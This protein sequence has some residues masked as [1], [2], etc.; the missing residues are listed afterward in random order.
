MRQ[1]I[2]TLVIA[3]AA[4]LAATPASLA[5]GSCEPIALAGQTQLNFGNGRIEG[6][7]TGTLAREPISIFSSTAIVAQEQRGAV[8]FLTTSHTFTVVG[9]A[10]DGEQMT[11]LDH[12]RLVPLPTAG[13]FRAVSNVDI[14]S[15][16]S[17]FVTA[18]GTIDFRGGIT[19]T[20]TQM[21][22]QVCGL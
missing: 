1:L 18:I 2:A 10:H 7:L 16:G 8:S 21:H 20:W 17:G 22:G 12:A 19:A 11:T 9:G 13:V 14:V 3:A 6:M 4:A 5:G 15:G